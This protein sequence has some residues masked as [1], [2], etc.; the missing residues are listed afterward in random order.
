L[1]TTKDPLR[2]P[3][4]PRGPALADG[5]SIVLG[6]PTYCLARI[7]SSAERAA[8]RFIRDRRDLPFLKLMAL[9]S[10]TVVPTGVALFVP[11]AFRWWLAALHLGLVVYFMGPFILMLHNTSHRTLFNRRWRWMTP[12]IP[13]VLGPFFGE[14]PETYFAHHV[15]MHH[16]ENN[17]ED[18]LSSTLS[19]RRDSLVE[20][21]RYFSRFFFLGIFQV[22]RYFARRR[23]RSLMV[24]CLLGETSFV[25]G[26]AVLFLCFDWRAAFVVFVVPLIIT[27][28]GMMA[29]NWGQH[30][31]V[32]ESAPDN[33]Y[34]NSVTC[35]NASYNRR[36]F[37]DGYHIGHHLKA[38][39]HWTEMPEDFARNIDTYT[40]ERA[41]V[42]TGV[43]FF[44]VWLF[45]MLKRYDWLAER[46]VPLGGTSSI[47]ER[48]E[49]LQTRAQWTRG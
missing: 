2:D 16:P 27:R 19:Y 13:W 43:D 35:I 33:A 6:D 17:L 5:A 41:I 38:S 48:I 32:D 1:S 20:F 7:P 30:A 34:R 14:S 10:V 42:F 26:V 23:R 21:A 39:R 28:F 45:L 46:M 40:A 4:D 3:G 22:T 9:S 8:E 18:D 25:A 12:Y 24:R 11:G 31:F 49:L 37:N 44:G 15:G 47:A 29:G 36:C